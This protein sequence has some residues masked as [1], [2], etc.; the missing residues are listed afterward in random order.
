MNI[1]RKLQFGE[2]TL[3]AHDA[4]SAAVPYFLAGRKMYHVGTSGGGIQRIGAE[5]LIGEMGGTWAHPIKVADGL[6]V[7]LFDDNGTLAQ[8]SETEMTEL[9]SHVAWQ[10]QVTG[11]AAHRRDFVAEE[12]AA[13]VSLIELRNATDTAR[14]GQI[15]LTIW[16]KFLGCW[17]GGMT[18]SESEYWLD[19]STVLGYDR[20]WQG[21][22][23]VACGTGLPPRECRIETHEG[24]TSATLVFPFELGPGESQ[25]IEFV[26]AADH[27]RGHEGARHLFDQ[28]LGQ[29]ERLL[30]EKIAR[31]SE[32]TFTGVALE[33]PDQQ[34]NYSFNLAK[35]NLQ[36]LVA[37][38]GP[39]LPP[40]FLAGVPEYPQL[41]G[42][43]N[44]Y[45]TAGA[46]AAGFADVARSTLLA[47]AD[48]AGRACGRV[49]HE[50]TTNGRVFH[51]G[52]TQ[53]TPQLAIA[54]WDFFRWTGDMP[55]LRRL[56]PICR[57]GVMD[58]LPS[59]W[60]M[61]HVLPYP[62]GDA[63]VERHGMGPY[64]LDSVC[65]LHEA[66]EKLREMALVLDLP[67]DV[68]TYERRMAEIAARFDQDWWI[69]SE[70]MY[71][72]SLEVDLKQRLDG[73][74]TVVLPMQLGLGDP[75]HHARSWQRLERDWLNEHGLVHTRGEDERVWTLPT[76]LAALAAFRYGRPELGVQ[77]LQSI[78]GTAS[79]GMLG[80]FKELIPIGLCFVQLWSAGLYIQGLLE[81]ALGLSPLAH[82]HTLRIR[83]CLPDAWPT[84]Q[85][86]AITLG[87]H[88]L[89][90]IIGQATLDVSH[91]RGNYPLCILFHL[92]E[93]SGP[94]RASAP[95]AARE[96][97]DGSERW[98]ELVLEAGKAATVSA[99]ASGVD[100][101][102][103]SQ[104]AELS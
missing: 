44:E 94:L 21:R 61:L 101:Q 69:E 53:E 8:P 75:A 31:Y 19:G 33:T 46:V 28:V 22:W 100:V 73:H 2:Y 43:D 45:N 25:L 26:L 55:L 99:S 83:P 36:M 10:Y 60:A 85:L 93:G 35:A 92:P 67:D 29:G 47:L 40:Y 34:V 20:L 12:Q 103:I 49:P 13:F 16:L 71:A 68:A 59:F 84:V 17:F 76:G 1:R 102:D 58:M 18:T 98:L 89:S 39:N 14:R 78:A 23:G 38:Y 91:A 81:G 41:F 32:K 50:V 87:E 27:Q 63:M 80:A 64:K 104:H 97:G 88:T 82:R 66:Y 95:F 54:T 3:P 48:F 74:W 90:L 37:D 72:D 65:Y 15:H 86:N 62:V 57:E 42:C 9:L 52:N 24:G 56:Y 6:T 79:Y 4:D 77:L 70:T 5:H 11:L 7:G 30:Q 51:P 96:Y